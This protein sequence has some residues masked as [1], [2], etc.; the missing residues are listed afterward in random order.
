MNLSYPAHRFQRISLCLVLL[1]TT[2]VAQD[3]AFD[4]I[5][6]TEEFH[7]EGIA[8]G[9]INGDEILDI[10]SGPFW[11]QGPEFKKRFRY[12]QYDPSN[13][14]ISADRSLSIKGYS[15][16]FFTWTD[17]LD[18]DG[19]TDILT[20][21]MPG[22]AAFWFENP[23]NSELKHQNWVRRNVLN[24]ISNESPTYIDLTGDGKRELVCLHQGN[25]VYIRRQTVKGLVSFS[26]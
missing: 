8:A 22:N 20:V 23:N 3:V 15:Q 9:D 10:V 5:T 24:D 1:A 7:S 12:M 11:Y 19:D 18:E 14:R 4:K 16:H 17:D 25:Y 26:R 13:S 6:L 21:G 2:S